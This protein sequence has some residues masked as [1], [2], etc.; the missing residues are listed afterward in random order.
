IDSNSPCIADAADRSHRF[1]LEYVSP[2]AKSAQVAFGTEKIER[3]PQLLIHRGNHIV[4]CR[5]F[6][7]FGPLKGPK[8]KGSAVFE[9][10]VETRELVLLLVHKAADQPHS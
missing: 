5:E 2:Q 8:P 1:E 9:S 6:A 10:V 4:D 7:G 3:V